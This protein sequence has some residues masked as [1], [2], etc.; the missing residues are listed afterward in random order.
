[1]ILGDPWTLKVGRRPSRGLG[2]YGRRK[3][4]AG[5]AH[6]VSRTGKTGICQVFLGVTITADSIA[7]CPI[8]LVGR[9]GVPR[10]RKAKANARDARAWQVPANGETS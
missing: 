6:I 8:T 4:M 2:Q 10:V 3:V 7:V 5:A 9:D 1:M